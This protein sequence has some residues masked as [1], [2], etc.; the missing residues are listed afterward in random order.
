MK[1]TKKQPKKLWY[2]W[3]EIMAET[4]DTPEKKAEFEKF[5]EKYNKEIEREFLREIGQRLRKQRL[6]KRLTQENL[7]KLVQTDRTAITRVE[8]GRQNIS[9]GYLSRIA[10][11]L[12]LSCQIRIVN[13]KEKVLS[14]N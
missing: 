3:A 10:S 13:S 12:G 7:A 2:T 14:T 6:K 11:A 5:S 9:F 8:N 1:T 4:Y